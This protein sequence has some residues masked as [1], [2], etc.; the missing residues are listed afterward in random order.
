M[1]YSADGGYCSVDWCVQ[2]GYEILEWSDY[3]NKEIKPKDLLKNGCIVE[4]RDK[5]RL[6]VILGCENSY[7]DGITEDI[8]VNYEE[9]RLI[10]M[11]DYDCEL[12]STFSSDIDIMKIIKPCHPYQ[13][14]DKDYKSD[15][16]KEELLWERKE[17]PT[18]DEQIKQMLEDYKE[19]QN[20]NTDELLKMIKEKLEE[21]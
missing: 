4:T 9:R 1:C 18:A 11:G 3:M 6:T 16:S 2:N 20:Q 5:I 12:I 14:F 8:L 19:K 21:K 13:L 15:T 10:K 17:E 7:E